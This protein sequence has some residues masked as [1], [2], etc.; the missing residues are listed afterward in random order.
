[1]KDSFYRETGDRESANGKKTFEIRTTA[2]H[3]HLENKLLRIHRGKSE[4]SEA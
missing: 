4:E 3:A 1:M 2:E